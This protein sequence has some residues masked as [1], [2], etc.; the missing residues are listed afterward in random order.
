[1][2]AVYTRGAQKKT[3]NPP[4][5]V[6]ENVRSESETFK[7]FSCLTKPHA[8]AGDSFQRMRRGVANRTVPRSRSVVDLRG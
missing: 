3:H 7:L 2:R 1:M 5:F 4:S 6:T 8:S